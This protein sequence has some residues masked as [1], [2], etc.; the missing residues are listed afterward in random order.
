[1]PHYVDGF[2]LPVPKR[3]ID[4]YRKLARLA[5]RIW[6]EHGALQYVEAVHEDMK[7]KGFPKL[8]KTKRGEVVVMSYIVYKSRAHRDRVLKKVMNDERLS[9][10]M[11][12]KELPFD[13]KRMVWGG[14]LTIVEA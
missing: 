2:V 8:V 6:R 3:N 13:L 11:D 1:M 9:V 4:K 14:F 5:G 10:M 12:P 7:T